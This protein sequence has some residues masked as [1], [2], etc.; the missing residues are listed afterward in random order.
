M[1]PHVDPYKRRMR[2]LPVVVA[3]LAGPLLLVACDDSSG[4]ERAVGLMDMGMRNLVD[5]L[6]EDMGEVDAS[7]DAA[8]EDVG[9]L[10]QGMVGD[11]PPPLDS[12]RDPLCISPPEPPEQ[13]PIDLRARCREGGAPLRIR[14]IR[15]NRCA[16]Y[17]RLSDAFPGRDLFF[18]EVVVTGVFG[19]DFTIA[20][21]DGG[22]YSGLWVFNRAHLPVD[23]LRPG[24]RLRISGEVIEFYTLTEMVPANEG[25]EILGQ[26]EPLEP[27]LV[28]DPARIADGGDLF[29][30]L[31]SVLVEV[32]NVRVSETEPDCPADFGMFVVS[33]GLRID[34]EGEHGFEPARADLLLRA[35]GLLHF[36]FEHSKL[37]PRGADDLEPV[38]CGGVPDKC[39]AAEC[40]VEVDA[41]ES[42]ELVIN[43]LQINPIGDDRLGEFLEIYNP[44]GDLEVEGWW[45]QSCEGQRANLA[46]RISGDGFHVLVGDRDRGANGG[47]ESDGEM[48]DLFLP[49]GFGSVLIFKADGT[50]VDQVRYEPEGD[51]PDRTPGRSIEL[52]DPQ[53][54]NRVGGNWREAE[55][56][57][58]DDSRGSPGRRN[59]N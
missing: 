38:G 28:A 12:G 25:I 41:E 31:E 58:G 59:G 52:R 14:D 40:P 3:L 42:G 48:Q 39:E 4:G 32:R 17:E 34:D 33:G 23:E 7:P 30:A 46:G 9:A 55:R 1:W 24:T 54:D 36:S 10:D 21:P 8:T 29:E 2:T 43:E 16:D 11:G 27:I 13:L 47:V 53:Q 19:D 49:N 22:T 50:L 6:R 15:D 18:E 57:Y 45:V 20:D 5:A 37:L 35:T 44:G 26:G 56:R 51:W